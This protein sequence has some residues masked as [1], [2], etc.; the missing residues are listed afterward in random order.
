MNYQRRVCFV[1]S[2]ELKFLVEESKETNSDIAKIVNQNVMKKNSKK[3][4]LLNIKIYKKKLVLL[5]LVV[6]VCAIVQA[7]YKG[8][9][10]HY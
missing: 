1:I 8:V 4:R 10:S 7:R 6:I 9:R 5:L 3:R 2:V